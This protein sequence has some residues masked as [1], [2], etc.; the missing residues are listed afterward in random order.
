MDYYYHCGVN[1]EVT[2]SLQ[3]DPYNSFFFC[4]QLTLTLFVG[5]SKQEKEEEWKGVKS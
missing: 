1:T 4:S 2:E 3:I 5:S